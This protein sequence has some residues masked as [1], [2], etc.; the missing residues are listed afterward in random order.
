[1]WKWLLR[2]LLVV[3]T[4][5]AV[6]FLLPNIYVNA[7]RRLPEPVITEEDKNIFVGTI[8]EIVPNTYPDPM[9]ITAKVG[10]EGAISY[11]IDY[12]DLIS[13]KLEKVGVS[14]LAI[15]STPSNEAGDETAPAEFL[16]INFSMPK[17]VF[18]NDYE[19]VI[20]YAIT[21]EGAETITKRDFT[22]AL[23]LSLFGV[24]SRLANF[25][26][27]SGI[28]PDIAVSYTIGETFSLN[29]DVQLIWR[30]IQAAGFYDVR[31]RT[32]TNADE[33]RLEFIFPQYYGQAS[34]QQ[35]ANLFVTKGTL[36]MWEHQDGAGPRDEILSS[37][38]GADYV[39]VPSDL[40]IA[41]IAS[42]RIEPRSSIA[43]GTSVWRISFKEAARARLISNLQA[44]GYADP[45]DPNSTQSADFKPL[46]IAID[47]Y[48]AF[49]L[50]FQQDLDML[51]IPA[52]VAGDEQS[53]RAQATYFIDASGIQGS[54]TAPV[55]SNLPTVVISG[56]SFMLVGGL[57]VT[58][59]AVVIR[60]GWVYGWRR[61]VRFSAYI[62]YYLLATFVI[63][64]LLASTLSMF[65][66]LSVGFV[67]VIAISALWQFAARRTVEALQRTSSLFA[68]IFVLSL[69]ILFALGQA[70]QY[71]EILSLVGL[72]SIIALA[73]MQALVLI[74]NR[75]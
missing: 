35:L 61:A 50:G 45:T 33:N 49:Y 27:G 68:Y 69:G 52:L 1:M 36:Q 38:M 58:L 18:R 31:V 15:V 5:L 21:S 11:E 73:Y 37:I 65:A 75:D 74:Y 66:V 16:S 22:L 23:D 30:R 12:A 3:S 9:V 48:P 29:S 59:L 42:L 10:I 71:F 20:R 39:P 62:G 17:S 7:P 72:T 47:G 41:D 13:Q 34:A 26:L 46:I 53:L 28:Y 6:G 24:D 54:F 60:F 57:L 14:G 56:T 43:T 8:L 64:K 32:I 40:S 19:K 70:G 51:A 55:V 44:A 67:A 4:L 2:I 25:Q 63:L